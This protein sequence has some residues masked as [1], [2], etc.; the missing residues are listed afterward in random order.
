[1]RPNKMYQ[2]ILK[3]LCIK[4]TKFSKECGLD[5]SLDSFTSFDL[6]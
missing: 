4:P 2:F 1:M 5:I 3:N 6:I